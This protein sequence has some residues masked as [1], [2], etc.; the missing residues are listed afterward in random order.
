M[1]KRASIKELIEIARELR[2]TGGV[3]HGLFTKLRPKDVQD[4]MSDMTP[5][6]PAGV[7]IGQRMYHL[8]EEMSEIPKCPVCEKDRAWYRYSNGYFETCGDKHCKQTVKAEKFKETVSSDEF[9][10]KKKEWFGKQKQTM[11]ERYGVDHN[12]KGDLRKT[13]EETMLERYG[14]KHA[15][16]GEEAQEKRR[17]TTEERHGTLDMFSLGRETVKEKYGVENAM[18]NEEVKK[19]NRMNMKKALNDITR[20]KLK[21]HCIQMIGDSV[22]PYHLHCEGCDT[23]FK[24]SNATVNTNLRRGESPCPRCN[25]PSLTSSRMEKEM[26]SYIKSIYNG[27]IEENRFYLQ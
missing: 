1:K 5:E 19:R 14:V 24:S 11:L 7:E 20:D 6:L 3:A 27:K 22:D 15:L 2:D 10:D 21:K 26:L 13:G 23:C 17:R 8:R 12:W 4:E 9:A 18:Q 16:Q 25:P